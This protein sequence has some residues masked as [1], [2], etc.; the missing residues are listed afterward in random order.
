ML[1]DT[2]AL[3]GHE[4]SA[5]IVQLAVGYEHVCA[6]LEGGEITCWGN[7]DY[8]QT[9]VSGAGFVGLSAGCTNTCAWDGSGNVTCWGWEEWDNTV[10]PA[11]SIAT[12]STGFA[13]SCGLT[14]DTGVAV[15]WGQDLMDET[16]P[17]S[18]GPPYASIHSGVTTTCALSDVGILKCW[19]WDL[20]QPNYAGFTDVA[21]GYEYG[22]AVNADQKVVCWGANEYGQADPPEGVR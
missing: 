8:G 4:P 22:C 3:D 6:L 11:V 19:G 17:P 5:A 20:H 18:S 10:P 13:Y 12:V 2:A 15:C 7:N 21:L 9:A 1:G 16:E 14:T